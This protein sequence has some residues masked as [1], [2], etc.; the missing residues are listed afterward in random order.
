M[1]NGLTTLMALKACDNPWF[2]CNLYKWLNKALD[3]V[4]NNNISRL[5]TERKL[6]RKTS[7]NVG[8]TRRRLFITP[9]SDTSASNYFTPTYLD[10]LNTPHI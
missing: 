4:K 5:L 3:K 8:L 1:E 9:L 10:V 6:L 7:N 2:A